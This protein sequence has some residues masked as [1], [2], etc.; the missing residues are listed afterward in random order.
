MT[1]ALNVPEITI[2]PS[3]IPTGVPD[4]S[5]YAWKMKVYE[6]SIFD[7]EDHGDEFDSVEEALAHAYSVFH[8]LVNH[9]HLFPANIEQ[10]F[11]VTIRKQ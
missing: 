4:K 7:S 8:N 10:E 9:R 11:R 3:S 1:T 5:L 2:L 6:D